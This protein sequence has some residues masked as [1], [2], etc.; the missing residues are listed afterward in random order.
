V[1]LNRSLA[2]LLAVVLA[3]TLVA[4]ACGDDPD[5]ASVDGGDT[6]TQDDIDALL[7]PVSTDGNAATVGDESLTGAGVAALADQPGAGVIDRAAAAIVITDWVRN[8]LWYAEL[9]AGGLTDVQPY[10]DESR[11]EFE[12]FVAANPGADVPPID[13]AAGLELIRSV[14]LGPAIADYLID[15]QGVVIEWPAQLCSNHILLDTEEEALAAIARLEAGEEF[16]S[17]AIE[18]STGP[19]G[20]SG[21]VLGCVDPAGFVSE[22]VDGA[23][24]LGGPGVTP[25]VQTEFGWHVIEVLSFESTPSDDPTDIQNAAL[26]TPEF[27]VLQS[28]VIAREVTVDPRYGEWDQLTASVV[29][30]G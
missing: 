19:S 20:P 4:T 13:S 24:A 29:A 30:A 26:S 22:F 6:L 18:L 9:A 21:G 27:T 17:L 14:A 28:E 1:S 25:P 23:A 2:R 12:A 15:I 10:L 7:D 8:E 5:V 11:R 16:A 3:L